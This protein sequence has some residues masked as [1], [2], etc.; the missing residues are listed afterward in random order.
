MKR[1]HVN[2]MVKDLEA[3]IRFYS[4]LFGEEPTFQKEGYARWMIED[5][6]VNFAMEQVAGDAGIEHLGIQ[7]ET[8]E[9]L[10][11]LRERLAGAGLALDHDG[12]TV[13][14]YARSNKDWV[15]DGQGIPWEVFY[16]HGSAETY[17]APRQVQRAGG[18]EPGGAAVCCE[19]KRGPVK[20]APECC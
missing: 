6:R 1:L 11:Q 5:P 14:C 12:E 18:E 17:G 9:D 2:L 7:A 16:T 19:T 3:S 4:R 13:C 20:T 15:T 10:T 8:R